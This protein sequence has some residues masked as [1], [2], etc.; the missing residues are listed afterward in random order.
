MK[1]AISFAV[2]LLAAATMLGEAPIHTDAPA[3][4]IVGY[5][6]DSGCVYRFQE[7]VKPLP[8]GCLEACVR[9]ASPL[10]ILTKKGEVYHPISTKMPDADIRPTLLPFAG[11]LVKITGHIYERGGSKAI[12]VEQ[13]EGVK[14]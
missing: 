4:S 9:A 1:R 10:V 8:N 14:E 12:A 6:R 2:M 3:K 5:L 11:K 13:I 7:V